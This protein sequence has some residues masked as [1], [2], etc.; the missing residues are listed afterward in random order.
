MKLIDRLRERRNSAAT[1]I[2]SAQRRLVQHA[3]DGG[4]NRKFRRAKADHFD[5]V[6]IEWAMAHPRIGTGLCPVCEHFGEDC[7]GKPRPHPRRYIKV[8]NVKRHP[9]GKAA[10]V[11]GATSYDVYREVQA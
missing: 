8:A 10:E 9:F 3:Q 4:D 6:M 5:V 1:R 7:L 11:K 2:N